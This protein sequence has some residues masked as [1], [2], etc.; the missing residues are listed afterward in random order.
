MYTA[1]KNLTRNETSL[2]GAELA[3]ATE[4]QAG[5]L[6]PDLSQNGYGQT[7]APVLPEA[8]IGALAPLRAPEVGGCGGGGAG[9][10]A[11]HAAFAAFQA[12]AYHQKLNAMKM[13]LL[14]ERHLLCRLECCRPGSSNRQCGCFA[15]AVHAAAAGGGLCM[16][17]CGGDPGGLGARVAPVGFRGA[18]LGGAALPFLGGADGGAIGHSEYMRVEDDGSVVLNNLGWCTIFS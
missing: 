7:P 17:P 15:R 8:A 1:N 18:Q 3:S 6:D 11:A 2:D 12:V 4:T 5:G 16:A 13:L 9:G 10:A 14:M